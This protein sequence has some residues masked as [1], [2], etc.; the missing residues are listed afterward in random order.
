MA[1]KIGSVDQAVIDLENLQTCYVIIAL[2]KEK[3]NWIS[4]IKFSLLSG[5]FRLFLIRFLIS[6]DLG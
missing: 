1:E 5:T 2:E 4:L 3:K 6:V